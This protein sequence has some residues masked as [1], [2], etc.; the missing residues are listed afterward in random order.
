MV[1]PIVTLCCAGPLS[2]HD[3]NRNRSG[4]WPRL[5]APSCD[6]G[7]GHRPDPSRPVVDHLQPGRTGR[8]RDL[9]GLRQNRHRLRVGQSVG[10]GRGQSDFVVAVVAVILDREL[11]LRTATGSGRVLMTGSAWTV[12]DD[13]RPGEDRRSAIGIGRQPE[14]VI[15]SPTLYRSDG[16]GAV[17]VATGGPTPTSIRTVSV[18][19]PPRLSLTVKV[20]V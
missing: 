9:D 13:D 2:D 16:D 17:I 14:N 10:V 19:T 8:Q 1:A 7:P 4:A 15:T 3:P 6:R 5:N 18:V 12:V 11:S 20:A